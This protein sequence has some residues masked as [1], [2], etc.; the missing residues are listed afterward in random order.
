MTGGVHVRVGWHQDLLAG[1]VALLV[2]ALTVPVM[3]IGDE[4]AVFRHVHGYARI[5]VL[6]ITAFA[7][8]AASIPIVQ[9]ERVRRHSHG[10]ATGSLLPVAEVALPSFAETVVGEM[11]VRGKGDARASVADALIAAVADPART[12]RGKVRV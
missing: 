1:A 6:A 10:K 11:R 5:F 7:Q 9:R 8:P 4:V 2:A 12:R 3:T